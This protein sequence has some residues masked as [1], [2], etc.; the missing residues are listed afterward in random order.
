MGKTYDNVFQHLFTHFPDNHQQ[1]PRAL[2]LG[3]LQSQEQMPE[4]ASSGFTM[5]SSPSLTRQSSSF[6][7]QDT[8][9]F[10]PS[11]NI[12][13][14]EDLILTN[15]VSSTEEGLLTAPTRGGY[16]DRHNVPW[17]PVSS[18]PPVSNDITSHPMTGRV[19]AA[20]GTVSF[21]T[22]KH[23]VNRESNN[24]YN[25]WR[26]P[27]ASMPD[28]LLSPVQAQ[29]PFPIG[30][31]HRGARSTISTIEGDGFI[32]DGSMSG[33]IMSAAMAMSL[34]QNASSSITNERFSAFNT[35][36]DQ[37]MQQPLTP[38]LPDSLSIEF[39]RK[40]QDRAAKSKPYCCN[41]PGCDRLE[42]FSSESDL[43]RHKRTRHNIPS[44]RRPNRSWRCQACQTD[45]K[46]RNNTK[47]WLRLDNFRDHCRKSHKNQDVN[48]LVARSELLQPGTSITN[49]RD[50]AGLFPEMGPTIS[51]LDQTGYEPKGKALMRKNEVNVVLPPDEYRDPPFAVVIPDNLDITSRSA[52]N[53]RLAFDPA[54]IPLFS[55]KSLRVNTHTSSRSSMQESSPIVK[56][57]MAK[58]EGEH[59]FSD[60]TLNTFLTHLLGDLTKTLNLDQPAA[61]QAHLVVTRGL[62]Q[63]VEGNFDTNEDAEGLS[64]AS[65]SSTVESGSTPSQQI[66]KRFVCPKIG[67]NGSFVRQSE[68]T[69]HAKRHTRPWTCIW[70]GCMTKRPFGSKA[71]W[72]RHEASVHWG[73]E[74]YRCLEESAKRENCM[75]EFSRGDQYKVHLKKDHNIVNE[76]RLRG[77]LEQDRQVN[78]LP[79]EYLCGFCKQMRPTMGD[80]EDAWNERFE[81]IERHFRNGLGR[82]DWTAHEKPIISDRNHKGNSARQ[83]LRQRHLAFAQDD[84]SFDAGFDVISNGSSSGMSITTTRNQNN[85][86]AR[87]KNTSV[88]D[89][90]SHSPRIKRLRA[91]DPDDDECSIASS[92]VSR[93]RTNHGQ[94]NQM[95]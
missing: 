61:E 55:T 15:T 10:S 74:T 91:E 56:P 89:D 67:C 14:T 69:K 75:K 22:A 19:T 51:Y 90:E 17:F 50:L 57:D 30:S 1:D 95:A 76:L 35:E 42:G 44:S 23:S 27:P 37:F 52:G 46:G 54:S 12:F 49:H 31:Y 94:Y 78:P 34:N 20:P 13:N 59:T 33:D 63:L 60:A 64:L 83:G 36:T 32:D 65:S 93:S 9:M 6:L 68:L 39:T 25:A 29:H 85:K 43:D 21:L 88:T 77:K 53:T 2:R 70:P 16:L 81:H 72:K 7:D 41:F 62:K 86:N 79:L 18:I 3:H 80:T 4:K 11:S 45:G 92:S 5:A 38:D 40:L 28:S 66:A 8:E 58:E 73:H 26:E 82:T 24:Q 48:D 71:D 87:S 84:V 47:T